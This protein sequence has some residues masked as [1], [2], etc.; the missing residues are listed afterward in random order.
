M[1]LSFINVTPQMFPTLAGIFVVAGV[2]YFLGIYSGA[3]WFPVVSTESGLT[4]KEKQMLSEL[5]HV[6]LG[7]HAAREFDQEYNNHPEEH[8]LDELKSHD[9][10][11]YNYTNK[12]G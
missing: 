8:L 4:P 9:E 11:W 7:E 12:K 5:Y 2:C 1:I 6:V 10:Q 3:Y